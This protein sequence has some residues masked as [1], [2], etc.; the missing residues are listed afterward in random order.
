M[1]EYELT[2]EIIRLSRAATWRGEVGVL[3]ASG[4]TRL[5]L[6]E[7]RD[8]CEYASSLPLRLLA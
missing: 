8:R 3:A 7:S 4:P 5:W 6:S 1:P 2:Q